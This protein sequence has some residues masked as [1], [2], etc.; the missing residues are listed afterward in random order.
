MKKH[1]TYAWIIMFV[2]MFMSAFLTYPLI[3]KYIDQNNIEN[4]E[5]AEFPVLSLDN[6]TKY[7]QLFE[8]WYNDT[9]PY[10]DVLIQSNSK[11]AF[12]GFKESASESVVAGKDN[13][14]FLSDT[15]PD[16]KRTNLYTPEQLEAI[17]IKLE[18]NDRYFQKRNIDFIVFIA[19]NKASI[20]GESFLPDYIY[21]EDCA[22]RT[23]Q[24]V[25]YI[26]QNTNVTIVFPENEIQ[27][28]TQAYPEHPLYLHLDTHW[29]Y[30]G[31][32]CGTR[33]LLRELDIELPAIDEITLEETNSP[34]LLWNGYDLSNMMG[35][36]GELTQDINYNVDYGSDSEIIWNGD[37]LTNYSDFLSICQ[38]S[39]NAPDKRKVMFIRDSFGSA[40]LPFIASEF[41]EVYSP[42]TS[43]PFN[44][45][46]IDAVSPDIIIYEYAERADIRN[47]ELIE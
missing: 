7:H 46:V 28:L 29:N 38:T 45:A 15:M 40:M 27:E 33:A 31:S 14:L 41:S 25:D 30:L 1:M 44:P 12:Y 11:L 21:R 16:Y 10:R 22:S 6:Y 2:I 23:E 47:I 8:A 13:W 37:T 5:K 35:M 34:T 24:L 9:L 3:S 43:L 32:Y 4:R 39:S 36:T 17:R 18:E 26:R 19:P 20:Y 42:H